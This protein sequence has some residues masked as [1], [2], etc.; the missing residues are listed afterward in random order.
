MLVQPSQLQRCQSEENRMTTVDFITEL[1][2]RIDAAMTDIPKH[3]Q[4]S[5]YPSEVVTLAFMFAL[6][7]VGNRPFYRWLARDWKACFPRLPERTRLFRL[8]KTHRQW[9]ERFLAAPTIFGVLDTYGIELIHPMREGRSPS[10]IG[11]KGSSHH[12][13][14]VGGKLCLLLNTFGWVV[15]WD[16]QTA[17]GSDH[18]FQPLVR[19]FEEQRVVLS[20]T[21]LH[22]ATGDPANLKLCKRGEWND[23]MRVETVWSMLTLVHHCKKVRHRV[24]AYFQARLAFTMATFTVLAQWYGLPVNE[25][26]F[27]PLSIAEFSL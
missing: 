27:V 18:T 8:C 6:K 19:Q 13:W 5:L 10:Q 14:I 2:C 17:N 22:A 24:W 9:T 20:E 4:A 15:A 16:G 3:P 25:D 1:F 7:G 26:G 21:A 12:R 23:R 11:K